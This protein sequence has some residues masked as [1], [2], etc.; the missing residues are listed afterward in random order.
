MKIFAMFLAALML[1][2]CAAFAGDPDEIIPTKQAAGCASGGLA[3]FDEDVDGNNCPP[4]DLE[5]G[6]GGV[7]LILGFAGM[8]DAFGVVDI[9]PLG[10]GGAA[11]ILE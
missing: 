1:T 8:L 9:F 2:A 3:L 5:K 7:I 6:I 4:T 10:S 11:V